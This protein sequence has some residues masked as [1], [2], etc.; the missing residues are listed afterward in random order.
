MGCGDDGVTQV[1]IRVCQNIR[2]KQTFCKLIAAFIGEG[3][4]SRATM[5]TKACDFLLL[6]IRCNACY[7]GLYHM[8]EG[9]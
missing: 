5:I 6:M 7:I 8:W 1:E 4:H 3:C 9:A 2:G